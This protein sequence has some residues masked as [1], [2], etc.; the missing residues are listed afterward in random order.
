M[1]S[2]NMLQVSSEFYV[3]KLNK[4]CKNLSLKYILKSTIDIC[5]YSSSVKI[6]LKKNEVIKIIAS[7]KKYHIINNYYITLI[8]IMTSKNCYNSS[9]TDHINPILSAI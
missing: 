7:Y 8:K 2:I 6:I 5:W 1:H 9:L 3:I 4:Y